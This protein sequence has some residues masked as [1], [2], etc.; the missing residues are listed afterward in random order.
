[1]NLQ[2]AKEFKKYVHD[3]VDNFWVKWENGLTVNQKTK[4]F[5]FEF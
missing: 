3:C 5:E 2:T 1:M 4:E